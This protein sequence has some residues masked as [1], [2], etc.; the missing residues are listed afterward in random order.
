LETVYLGEVR[1]TPPIADRDICQQ[2]GKFPVGNR[3]SGE[4]LMDAKTKRL[5][6]YGAQIERLSKDNSLAQSIA[7]AHL[8]DLLDLLRHE[9]VGPG[10]LMQAHVAQPP[11]P[12]IWITSEPIPD[13][14]LIFGEQALFGTSEPICF[15]LLDSSQLAQ[16]RNIPFLFHNEP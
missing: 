2:I 3:L 9:T 6:E 13:A 5:L 8:G 12:Q 1:T 15:D 4:V 10:H 11:L 16:V 14:D 7:L